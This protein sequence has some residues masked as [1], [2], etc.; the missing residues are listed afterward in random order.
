M[1]ICLCHGGMREPNI[2]CSWP[3]AN[4]PPMPMLPPP[5]EKKNM[6]TLLMPPPPP[7]KEETPP[8]EIFSSNRTQIAFFLPSF[9][10]V[11]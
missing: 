1:T 2:R 8:P 4:G 9:F 10:S 7:S 3:H 11:Q 5:L 6:A